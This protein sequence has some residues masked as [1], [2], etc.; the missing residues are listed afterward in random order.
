MYNKYGVINNE[1]NNIVKTIG[2]KQNK[3]NNWP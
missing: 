2:K 3:E 1:S